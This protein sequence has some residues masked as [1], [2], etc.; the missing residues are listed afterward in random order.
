[1]QGF[2]REQ[3][4]FK[5][6]FKLLSFNINFYRYAYEDYSERKGKRLI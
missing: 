5:C 4:F 2:P 6:I 1:M 3:A